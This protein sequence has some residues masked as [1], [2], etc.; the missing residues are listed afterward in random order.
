MGMRKQ[1]VFPFPVSEAM[2]EWSS[3]PRMAR[4][5]RS[6]VQR[7]LFIRSYHC[8]VESC[9]R[10]NLHR[11]RTFFCIKMWKVLC[12][13]QCCGSGFGIRCL[14]GPWI[15][16]QG[17]VKIRILILIRIRDEQPR[18][19]FGELRNNFWVQIL[20][21]FAA[22]PRWKKF[23]SGIRDGKNSDPGKIIPEPQH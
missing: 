15:R 18:S 22:H 10:I 19:Y 9:C 20:K 13:F 5:D 2:S 21:F 17:W 6:C 7:F 3:P 1:R 16:D 12:N 8:L 11:F 14:F 4:S 23:V